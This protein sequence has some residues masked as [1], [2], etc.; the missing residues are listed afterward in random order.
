MIEFITGKIGGGKTLLA[1]NFM[2]RDLELGRKV[3]TNIELD[4]D[5]VTKFLWKKK[6]V[7]FHEKQYQYH[8]FEEHPDFH[9]HISRGLVVGEVVVYCDETQLYYN[10]DDAR[11]LV[12]TCKELR[13]FLTQSRRFNVDIRFITQEMSTV[14]MQLRKQ[15]LWYY[16]CRDL[17][18]VSLSWLTG[19]TDMLGLR[20]KKIDLGGS[21][22]TIEKGKTKLDKNIFNMYSTTQFYD[23]FGKYL[24]ENMS[25]YE[26]LTKQDRKL[27]FIERY[28]KKPCAS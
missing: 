24:M 21:G 5:E 4:L 22:Q 27:T 19:K 26:S 13:S 6:G 7:R 8:N 1:T 9:N 17:R 23:S 20:W 25:V 15:A 3:I 10:S 14:W 2:I 12:K 18:G 16:D 11:E 28:F